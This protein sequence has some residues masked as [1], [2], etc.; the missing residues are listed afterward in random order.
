MLID[1]DRFIIAHKESIEKS[2]IFL[3]VCQL[4]FEKMTAQVLNKYSFAISENPSSFPP[5]Q[6]GISSTDWIQQIS[7]FH[8]GIFANFCDGNTLYAINVKF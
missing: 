2:L 6:T 4:D 5:F 8:I 7:P 1:Q 3:V